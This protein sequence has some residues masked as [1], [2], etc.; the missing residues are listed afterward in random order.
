MTDLDLATT[1]RDIANAL[2]TALERRHEVLDAI[3]DAENHA[4]AVSC[5]L[6]T[7]DAA[8]E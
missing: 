3:V 5:L 4:E 8:D 7:S 6:Y 1:R 2:L